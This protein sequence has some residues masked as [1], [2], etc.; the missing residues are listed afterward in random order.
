MYVIAFRAHFCHLPGLGQVGHSPVGVLGPWT[1]AQCGW[2]PSPPA[3]SNAL[4]PL[5]APWCPYIHS[6]PPDA[7]HP[8]W[9]L[10]AYT[11]CQTPMHPD[12]PYTTCHPNTPCWPLTWPHQPLH[13]LPVPTCTPD[14]PTPLLAPNAS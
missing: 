6:Q 14:T 12:T 9:L 13:S 8:C 4:H 7:L 5:L 2:P 1:G 11:P 3:T 10:S